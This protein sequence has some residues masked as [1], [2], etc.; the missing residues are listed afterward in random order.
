MFGTAL[1]TPF[2]LAGLT[3]ASLAQMPVARPLA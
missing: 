1:G 2:A 3:S